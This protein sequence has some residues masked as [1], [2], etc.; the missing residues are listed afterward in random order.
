MTER[1]A[2]SRKNP[3][4]RGRSKRQAGEPV[5][6][7]TE[8]ELLGG[9]EVSALCMVLATKGCSW[10]ISSGCTM[11]GYS[12]DSD[13]E[14]DDA[15]VMGQAEAA[16]S[17]ENGFEMVKI[18]NS[19]S[20]FDAREIGADAQKDILAACKDHGAQLVLV[21]SRPEYVS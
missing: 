11:C 7:W 6:A 8:K 9:K 3:K 5:A 1:K 20:F 17:K 21:E 4:N 14:A 12:H 16:L 18:Y 13:C 10:S 15:D 19:G 2:R